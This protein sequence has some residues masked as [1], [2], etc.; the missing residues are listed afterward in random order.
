M[1]LGFGW[2]EVFLKLSPDGSTSLLDMQILRVVPTCQIPYAA[3]SV[4]NS[5][6]GPS[7]LCLNS[8]PW[9]LSLLEL[10]NH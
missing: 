8:S 2:S 5:G 4:R 3:Y 9:L 1:Q 10:E 7:N 6:V